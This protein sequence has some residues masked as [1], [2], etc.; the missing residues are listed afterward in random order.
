MY[1]PF[2]NQG[3]QPCKR[4]T[5]YLFNQSIYIMLTN[6][7]IKLIMKRITVTQKEIQDAMKHRVQ[8]NKKKYYRKVKHKKASDKEA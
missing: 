7:L 3:L 1:E 8:R 5:Y 6:H 4:T 2:Y